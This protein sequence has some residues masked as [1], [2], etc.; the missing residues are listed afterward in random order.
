MPNDIVTVLTHKDYKTFSKL[1]TALDISWTNTVQTS[2][3]H[4]ASNLF[5][6]A[7][8]T[9]KLPSPTKAA[10]KPYFAHT[11]RVLFLILL[12]VVL[13]YQRHTFWSAI[14][15]SFLENDNTLKSKTLPV[16]LISFGAARWIAKTSV[17]G[18]LACHY[19]KFFLPNLPSSWREIPNYMGNVN[20]CIPTA[21]ISSF[22]LG[23]IA[24]IP[25]FKYFMGVSVDLSLLGI[26]CVCVHSAFCSVKRFVDKEILKALRLDDEYYAEL[27]A[28]QEERREQERREQERREQ[29][30]R[31][32]EKREKEEAEGEKN[33][34][35]KKDD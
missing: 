24:V 13:S 20:S 28:I 14:Q 31:E 5:V 9:N 33:V 2:W 10:K 18:M 21:F 30:R 1:S 29:E 15:R 12:N 11:K 6:H 7:L 35:S 19:T 22:V 16:M 17:T 23:M 25:P 32:Q 4:L 26:T 3:F 8:L 27:A 34:K